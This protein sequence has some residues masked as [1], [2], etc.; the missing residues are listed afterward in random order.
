[1]IPEFHDLFFISK[2]QEVVI[3]GKYVTC[4]HFISYFQPLVVVRVS[5][6]VEVSRGGY[7]FRTLQEVG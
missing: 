7:Y 6:E 4:S 3:P 1:M 2:A 5:A